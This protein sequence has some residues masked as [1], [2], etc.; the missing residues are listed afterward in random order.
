M[1]IKSYHLWLICFILACFINTSAQSFDDFDFDLDI[2][3]DSTPP[4]KASDDTLPPSQ[5]DEDFNDFDDFSQN[6][7]PPTRDTL[8]DTKDTPKSPSNSDD[9]TN[10]ENTPTTQYTG[11]NLLAKVRSGVPF[12]TEEMEAWILNTPNIN[13]CLD[14]GQTM[15][16]YLVA[17]HDNAD[18]LR[19]LI[20]NG[21]DLQT[22]C[23]PRYEALFI[24]AINNPSVQII[25][26]LLNNGANIVERDYE[27]NTALILA[28]TF[29]RSAKVINA[30]L[31]YGLK[32]YT[33]N[34]YGFNALMLAAYENGRLPILQT[35]ID[36]GSDVNGTDAEGHTPLMAA[37]IRGRDEVMQYL[38][39]RGA[40]FNAVDKNGVSV[41]DYYNKRY[42]LKTLNFTIDPMASPSERLVK[43]FQFIADNHH[44]Y[45]N[46]LKKSVFER[47]ADYAVAD[48]LK[49]LADV[50]VTDNYGCTA[51]LNAARNNNNFSVFE[52]LVEARAN[53]N[54]TCAGQKSALMF[55]SAH[56]KPDNKPAE[57]TKKAHYLVK[58]GADINTKDD[59]GN[60]ALMY[61]VGNQ[62]DNS[63]ILNL[64]NDGADLNTTNKMQETALWIAVRQEKA[65]ETLKLLLEYG[66]N[67]NIKDVKG[68]SPLWYQ[69][70]TNGNELITR[71]L[72]RGGAD[73]TITNSAGDTPLW[74]AINKGYSIMI[75]ENII[76]SKQNLEIRNEEGDTPLLYA[77]KH[78]FPASTV[79]L[80]LSQ[81][82]D[83]NAKDSKGYNIYDIM[84]SNQFFDATVKK[85]NRL[86]TEDW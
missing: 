41:L 3:T 46:A 28:A 81:G 61:A 29:N 49:N 67:P 1:R 75:I 13:T 34:Q 23:T 68:E 25:E 12:S 16:L 35:L 5:P 47:D 30:L 64:I 42:Y 70:R 32:T 39:A 82:A 7:T 22:H 10:E 52:K 57:Q 24:A 58:N 50:D 54:A 53:V 11:E 78:E 73:V 59:N 37:A 15:L 21:A 69:L 84:Q 56:A 44:R 38:I 2:N 72:L 19:L 85:R 6:E 27:K 55:L 66:A 65:P 71:A 31:D 4:Q 8:K 76:M 51:L 45:N 14:N 74:Y 43:E 83:P 79:K 33:T 17:R 20:E 18:A 40:D 62:A 63:Y 80:L 9:N 26:T 86:Q 48:A 60:T 77:V 36:N